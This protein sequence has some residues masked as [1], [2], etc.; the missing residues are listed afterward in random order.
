MLRRREVSGFTL[1]AM[2]VVWPFTLSGA[3][4]KPQEPKAPL[5][6]HEYLD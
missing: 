5:L 3:E 6:L 1:V 2:I 4:V